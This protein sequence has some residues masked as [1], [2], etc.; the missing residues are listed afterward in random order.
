MRFHIQ[1][2]KVVM[3]PVPYFINTDDQTF[4]SSAVSVFRKYGKR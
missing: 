1:E 2:L 4:G 3:K